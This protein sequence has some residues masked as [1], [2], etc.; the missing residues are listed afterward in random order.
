MVDDAMPNLSAGE[1]LVKAKSWA[2]I[3]EDIIPEVRLPDVFKHAFELHRSSFP[4]NHYDM[5]NA[6]YEIKEAEAK[7]KAKAAESA[8]KINAVAT[9]KE[10]HL[11]ISPEGEPDAGEIHH[12][13]WTNQGEDWISPCFE[14][15][16]KAYREWRRRMVEKH[17][18]SEP[19]PLKQ[20]TNVLEFK[21]KEAA[22][23]RLPPAE[24]AGILS[25]HNFLVR[26]LVADPA[27]RRN[28]E[29]IFDEG[30]NIFKLPH[31]ADLTYSVAV[32]KR[33]IETY[34]G[35]LEARDRC[36]KTENEDKTEL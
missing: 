9:C 24:I 2:R 14:C 18:G 31:R 27:A 16:P 36:L 23:I 12:W 25:E 22:E 11:H 4:I 33:K 32:V 17:G 21:K 34:R 7:A 5:K 29:L 35:I 26:E 28:L 6:W 30:A 1:K 20:L 19:E 15:R 10:K 13:N 8:P 3:L